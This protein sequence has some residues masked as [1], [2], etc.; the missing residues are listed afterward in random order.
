MNFHDIATYHC[1][2]DAFKFSLFLWTITEWNE[3]DNV[4]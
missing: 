3:I 2:T 4:E 1:R